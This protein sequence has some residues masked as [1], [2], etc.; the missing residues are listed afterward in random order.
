[1]RVFKHVFVLLLVSTVSACGT[2]FNVNDPALNGTGDDV[3]DTSSLDASL[4]ITGSWISNCL[5]LEDL[6]ASTAAKT[7]KVLAPN[8]AT[9]GID[10]IQSF[11]QLY[12][13]FE[14]DVMTFETLKWN[15]E[16][17]TE[18]YIRSNSSYAEHTLPGAL[19][20]A[21]QLSLNFIQT[22]LPSYDYQIVEIE[23]LAPE[24][25]VLELTQNT[26]QIEVNS[27]GLKVA[28]EGGVDDELSYAI[29][30]LSEQEG[31]EAFDILMGVASFESIEAMFEP[32]VILDFMANPGTYV[33]EAV[34]AGAKDEYLSDQKLTHNSAVDVTHQVFHLHRGEL[35]EGEMD[36]E[37]LVVLKPE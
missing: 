9:V 22:I 14:D 24:F 21:G 28:K 16:D 32:G 20:T 36:A 18:G 11:L 12:L 23:N 19:S 15:G 17:C 2:L 31:E 30:H 35:P 13:K 34:E 4:A 8:S 25:V 37:D 6:G 29:L 3:S 10:E 26:G 27:L 33:P 1:M 7:T 5:S